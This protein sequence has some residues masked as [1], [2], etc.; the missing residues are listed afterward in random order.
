MWPYL[1][2][3]RASASQLHCITIRVINAFS[4]P[5]LL[6]KAFGASMQSIAAIVCCQLID[7]SIQSKAGALYPVGTA[8]NNHTKV[9][10]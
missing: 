10:A 1:L 2:T 7:F 4:R 3:I 8:T 5:Q 6:V 9:G